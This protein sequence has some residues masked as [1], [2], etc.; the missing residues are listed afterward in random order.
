MNDLKK[1]IIMYLWK[2][3]VEFHNYI[4]GKLCSSPVPVV[5]KKTVSN[6]TFDTVFRDCCSSGDRTRTYD[7]WVMS[8]TSYQLLH[9]A[10]YFIIF[11]RTFIFVEPFQLLL[12]I[13]PDNYRDGTAIYFKV[14]LFCLIADAKVSNAR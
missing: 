3:V 10:M 9:P 11:L 7:L 8:P 14:R 4:E 6:L 1:D 2:Y 13:A 12:P 5:N